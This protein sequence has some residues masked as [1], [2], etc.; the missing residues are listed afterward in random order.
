M[1][2]EEIAKVAKIAFEESQLIPST[3]RIKALETIRQQL[4]LQKKEILAANAE[5]LKVC[6][7]CSQVVE[8]LIIII[9]SP[10]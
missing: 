6:G 7:I 1:S 10:T 4:E 5:D 8:M 9:G 3:E 2:S